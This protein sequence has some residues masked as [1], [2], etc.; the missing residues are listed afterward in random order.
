MEET[1]EQ[2]VKRVEEILRADIQWL[3]TTDDKR[4]ADVPVSKRW[5][6]HEGVTYDTHEGRFVVNHRECGTC[7]IGAHMMRLAAKDMGSGLPSRYDLLYGAR[8]TYYA[9]RALKITHEEVKDVWF[10]VLDNKETRVESDHW[11]EFQRLGHRLRDYAEELIAK[12]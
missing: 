7:A 8:V 11:T 1:I 9:S 4:L 6:P 5:N 3:L 12:L 2:K 10:A